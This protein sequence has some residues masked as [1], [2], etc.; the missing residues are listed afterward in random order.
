MFCES[1]TRL[2]RFPAQVAEIRGK[3]DDFCNFLRL[4]ACE[5]DRFS[6]KHWLFQITLFFFL[7]IPDVA[8][9]ILQAASFGPRCKEGCQSS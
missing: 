9:Y 3:C 7:R 8:Q 1:V 2:S 6:A 4:K 5:V